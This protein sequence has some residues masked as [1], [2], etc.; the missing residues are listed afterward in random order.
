MRHLTRAVSKDHR[1]LSHIENDPVC[2]KHPQIIQELKDLS[3]DEI[4]TV[5]DESDANDRDDAVD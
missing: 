2:R 5:R 3:V 1:I 4:V